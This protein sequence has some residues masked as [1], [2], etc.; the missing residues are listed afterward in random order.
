MQLFNITMRAYARAY[1]HIKEN[2]AVIIVIL[3]SAILLWVFMTRSPSQNNSYH[4]IQWINTPHPSG[5]YGDSNPA[6]RLLDVVKE[7]GPPDIIDKKSGGFAIWKKSTLQK[8]GFCWERIEIHDEQIPH[9]VPG[10]H[11]DFLYMQYKLNVPKDKINDVR[12]LSDS[13][14]YDPLKGVLSARCHF[15]GATY[16]TLLLAK[17]IAKGEIKLTDA[18]KNY[19]PFIFKTMK[20]HKTY[21]P[22]A[23]N[24]YIKELCKLS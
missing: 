20:E 18:K 4:G 2:C 3:L 14:T 19:G 6:A 16:A 10:P 23:Q 21:D 1:A 5:K 9:N 8:R 17:R 15:T 13:I 24:K 11:T 7:F 12:G 22:H